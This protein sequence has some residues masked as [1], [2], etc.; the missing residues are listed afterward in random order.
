MTWTHEGITLRDIRRLKQLYA[1]SVDHDDIEGSILISSDIFDERIKSY[2]LK[3]MKNI[4][5]D[6]I[7]ALKWNIH[8]TKG[9]YVKND[10]TDP[11]G[12]TKYPQNS[13]KWYISF[14]EIDGP[15]G[16]F[17]NILPKNPK[18]SWISQTEK[19]KF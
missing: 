3:D 2:F 5:R 14:L 11:D 17:D 9:Y 15:L 18:N 7:L 4:S 16:T 13:E 1:I 12:V 6:E 19:N 8:A 10:P